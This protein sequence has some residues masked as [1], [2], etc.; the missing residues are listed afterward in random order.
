MIGFS[1]SWLVSYLGSVSSCEAKYV[2][3]TLKVCWLMNLLMIESNS[4]T[5]QCTDSDNL[6]IVFK[7]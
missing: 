4:V 2:D 7:S 3:A 6:G 5:N 1:M